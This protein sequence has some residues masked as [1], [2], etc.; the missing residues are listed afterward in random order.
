MKLHRTIPLLLALVTSAATA[1]TTLAGWSNLAP[2]TD[3]R[4]QH[5]AT[6]LPSG[7][8]FMVGGDT[9]ETDGGGNPIALAS[10]RLFNPSTNQWIDGPLLQSP[11]FGHTAT[12]LA[13]GSVLLAGGRA[14]GPVR[15]TNANSL[16]YTP[17]TNGITATIGQLQLPRS[18]HTA[19]LLPS[20]E[21]LVTGGQGLA[22]QSAFQATEIY[23]PQTRTWRASTDMPGRRAHH[24]ATLVSGGRVLVVGGRDDNQNPTNSAWLREADGAW[25]DVLTPPGF[26]Y[27]AMHTAT[28]LPD[29]RV[30][31]VGGS[32]YLHDFIF[33][34]TSN[35]WLDL[36]ESLATEHFM[37]TATLLSTASPTVLVAGGYFAGTTRNQASTKAPIATP[38]ATTGQPGMTEQRRYH[39]ATLLSS[40]QVLVLGGYDNAS[41]TNTVELYT[42]APPNPPGNV[43]TQAGNGQ[44]TV[45]WQHLATGT[46][47]GSYTVIA[48]PGGQSCT[49]PYPQTNCTV[50]GLT[51]GTAYTF[52][53]RATALGD[54]PSVP[55]QATLPVTPMTAGPGP[56][57][58]SGNAQPVP[59]LGQ[60]GLALLAGLLGFTA[61]GLRR[62]TPDSMASGAC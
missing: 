27:R 8:I 52:T 45:S 42:H 35:S 53:V 30:L 50:T 48:T 20:G 59:T 7:Q 15:N 47:P 43:N 62:K 46:T 24:T 31:V 12:L 41:V 14:A 54:V 49:V 11:R 1:T 22:G 32:N 51:N 61:L 58:N 44:V 10:T 60:W 13:N 5:T 18:H 37:H 25:T 3:A 55:T 29:G 4:A 6:L 39:T 36:G 21:V 2:F 23:D 57:P 26:G 38:P 9:G 17:Q 40:G 28:L 19:T 16:L 56:N 34:P 33:D